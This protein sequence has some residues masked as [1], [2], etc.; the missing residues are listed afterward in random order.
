MIK[1]VR[2]MLERLEECDT[3]LTHVCR[4]PGEKI[5]ELLANTMAFISLYFYRHELN[6][7]TQ[8]EIFWT[9]RPWSVSRNKFIN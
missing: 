5:K 2:K 7:M 8:I 9:R 4:E 1:N 6:D 3:Y